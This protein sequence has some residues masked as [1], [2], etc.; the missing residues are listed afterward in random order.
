MRESLE[1]RPGESLF[2]WSN[3]LL[4]KLAQTTNNI[5]C[6][7]QFNRPDYYKIPS[8]FAVSQQPHT[9]KMGR[10]EMA[11]PEVR[12]NYSEEEKGSDKVMWSEI[13]LALK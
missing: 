6:L 13:E 10:N 12:V 4:I 2:K 11:P 9:I 3:L 5:A 8:I 7:S 1:D